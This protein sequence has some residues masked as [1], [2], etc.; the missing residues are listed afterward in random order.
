M[1][2]LFCSKR[3]NNV[4]IWDDITIFFNLNFRIAEKPSVSLFD[5]KLR[6]QDFA[7]NCIKIVIR[8]SPPYNS[9]NA[10]KS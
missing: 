4:L 10:N 6:K 3:A 5:L 8:V 7:E 2:N 9:K 1:L